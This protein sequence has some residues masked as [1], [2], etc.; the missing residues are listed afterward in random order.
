M[1][2]ARLPSLVAT[3]DSGCHKGNRDLMREFLHRTDYGIPD[4]VS[5]QVEITCASANIR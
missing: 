5:K 2:N 4:G 3:L 1:G